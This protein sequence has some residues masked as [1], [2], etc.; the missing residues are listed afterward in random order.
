MT[1]GTD[2]GHETG[3]D[4]S[5]AAATIR[6]MHERARHELTINRPAIFAAWSLVYLIGYGAAWLSVR[7]QHPYHALA[8]WALA[9]LI[10]LALMALAIT[11]QV[12]ER[13]ASGVGGASALRRR[14]YSLA[15]GTGLLGVWIMQAALRHADASQGTIGVFTASS[16]LLVAGVILVA[17]TAARLHW[18]TFG[19]GVWLI[20]V[21]AFSGFVGPAG[22]WGVDALAV[23]LPLLLIA[24]ITL[25]V[26]RP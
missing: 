17:G 15:L 25:A 2:I 4:A 6:E 24:A 3:M 1:D 5:S 20:A 13:A 19:L 22:T 23:G 8:T 12:T 11:A 10:L 7:G 16:P 9:L 26:R 21:A 18:P 14:S